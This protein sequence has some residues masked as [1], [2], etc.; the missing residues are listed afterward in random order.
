MNL[1]T[2]Q[3]IDKQNLNM[4]Y[5]TYINHLGL[6]IITQRIILVTVGS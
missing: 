3:D 5:F 6:N 1:L 4:E 2:S